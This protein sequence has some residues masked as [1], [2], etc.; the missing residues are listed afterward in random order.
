MTSRKK[1]FHQL[2]GPCEAAQIVYTQPAHVDKTLTLQDPE[3]N[4]VTSTEQP[5]TSEKAE[6]NKQP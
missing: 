1:C 6:I 4:E 3:T 5:M 2:A